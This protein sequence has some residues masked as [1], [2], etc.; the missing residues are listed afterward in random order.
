VGRPEL[1]AFAESLE[2]QRAR[3]GVMITTS[4]FSQ[5]AQ[6]YVTRI[7]KK[8]I[9]IDKEKLASA[10]DGAWSSVTEVAYY[11]VMKVYQD[12]FGEDE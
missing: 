6:D 10:D 1:Q 5:E 3:K 12:Y 7:E 9:L 8:M 11:P 4:Q 2:G